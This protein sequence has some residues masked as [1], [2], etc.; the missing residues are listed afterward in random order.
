MIKLIKQLS[1]WR[2]NCF[3]QFS[4][5]RRGFCSSQTANLGLNIREE[6]QQT[7]NY[8]NIDEIPNINQYLKE[9]LIKL[10]ERTKIKT[11]H[12]N[13][14]KSID[15]DENSTSIILC[16][17]Y[18]GRKFG[19]IFGIMNKMLEQ[20][21]KKDIKDKVL[22][23]EDLFK[24]T[25]EVFKKSSQNLPNN[26]LKKHLPPRGALIICQ[27]FDFATQFYR[28]ARR[29]DSENKLRMVRVG[30]S[31]QTVVPSVELHVFLNFLINIGS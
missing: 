30:T 20:K 23:D 25:K 7:Q 17:E 16:D 2:R 31:L 22:Q 28:I 18:H 15:D 13:I 27:Q 5:F 24:S 8:V 1:S 3:F 9:N 19:C 21:Q 26:Q 12:K 4:V 14:V 6:N 29:M 10:N 11:L